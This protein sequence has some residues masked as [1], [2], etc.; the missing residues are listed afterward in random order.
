MR[1]GNCPPRGGVA[2]N[3]LAAAAGN[4][5]QRPGKPGQ[6]AAITAAI[7]V[8]PSITHRLRADDCHS[9]TPNPDSVAGTA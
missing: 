4:G 5:R 3:V 6:A 2:P 8:I 9:R 1:D 7:D